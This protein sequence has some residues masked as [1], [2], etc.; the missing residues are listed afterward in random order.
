MILL[1]EFFSHELSHMIICDVRQFLSRVWMYCL[2]VGNRLVLIWVNAITPK[3]TRIFLTNSHKAAL[4]ILSVTLFYFFCSNTFLKIL[5]CIV[6]I[7]T[8]FTDFFYWVR[9]RGSTVSLETMTKKLIWTFEENQF[10]NATVPY[11]TVLY[12]TV[13]HGLNSF[14]FFGGILTHLGEEW[15]NFF[16]IK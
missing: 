1:N 9:H 11:C 14:R 15:E 13:L 16:R 3:N 7:H 6:G 10:G 8:Y 4:H 2:T 5:Y 12:C